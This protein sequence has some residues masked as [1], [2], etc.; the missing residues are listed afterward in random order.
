MRKSLPR[1]STANTSTTPRDSGTST[2]RSVMELPVSLD[3]RCSSARVVAS[4]AVSGGGCFTNA[5]TGT[6]GGAASTVLCSNLSLSSARRDSK[7]NSS[8]SVRLQRLVSASTAA[9]AAAR[10]KDC[11]DWTASDF[12][13]S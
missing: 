6:S 2:A 13:S 12:C 3:S 5:L 4:V 10:S 11:R 9:A 1:L 8:R 7:L